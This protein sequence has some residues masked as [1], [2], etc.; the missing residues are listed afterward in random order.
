MI[1]GDFWLVKRVKIFTEG[2]LQRNLYNLVC[3]IKKS[4]NQKEFAVELFYYVEDSF[5]NIKIECIIGALEDRRV[6][7]VLRCWTE[8]ALEDQFQFMTVSKK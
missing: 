4:L 5:K 2:V 8:K 7:R 6:P 1:W 3:K